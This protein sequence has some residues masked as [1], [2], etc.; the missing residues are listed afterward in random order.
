MSS[1]LIS[2]NASGC[3]SLSMHW[4]CFEYSQWKKEL[5]KLIEVTNQ[6]EVS[7]CQEICEAVKSTNTE[8][9]KNEIFK[10]GKIIFV[11]R[12]KEITQDIY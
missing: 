5:M 9:L 8:S 1:T 3:L 12:H 7:S 11:L 10:R 4:E 2:Q 6:L